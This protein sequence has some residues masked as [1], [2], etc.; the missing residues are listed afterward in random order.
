VA[1]D[2]IIDQFRLDPGPLQQAPQGNYAE[3][4]RRQIT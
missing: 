4:N 3:V 1:Q 2:N